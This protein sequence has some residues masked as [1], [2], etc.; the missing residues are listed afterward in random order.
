MEGN[1]SVTSVAISGCSVGMCMPACTKRDRAKGLNNL[2]GRAVL[3]L[4]HWW[5]CGELLCL[6]GNPSTSGAKGSEKR[7]KS[8]E[9]RDQ[10]VKVGQFL[11]VCCAGMLPWCLKLGALKVLV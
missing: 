8:L 5:P 7:R 1:A 4:C 2:V 3:Q 11:Q 6:W 10:Q 9:G